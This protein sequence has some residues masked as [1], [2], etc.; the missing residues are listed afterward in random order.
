MKPFVFKSR[1]KDN[2]NF[3]FMQYFEKKFL[4][5]LLILLI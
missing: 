2:P 3:S 4:T 5:F 1:H